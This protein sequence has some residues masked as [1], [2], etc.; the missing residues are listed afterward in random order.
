MCGEV[1]PK[2][3]WDI[4]VRYLQKGQKQDGLVVRKSCCVH[5]MAHHII[6]WGESIQSGRIPFFENYDHEKQTAKIE[7]HRG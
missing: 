3:S 1:E 2:E 4:H 6:S 5:C 7:A